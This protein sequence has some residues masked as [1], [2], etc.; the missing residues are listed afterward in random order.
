MIARPTRTIIVSIL[1]V[2]ALIFWC[3]VAFD[4][5]DTVVAGTYRFDGDGVVCS[6]VLKAD[7]TFAQEFKRGGTTSH[8]TGTWRRIGEG[9]IS[10]S[11]GFLPLPGEE[12]EPDGTSFADIH[13]TL[14]FLVT[15]R[16]RRYHVLW[17]GKRTSLTTDTPLGTYDGDEPGTPAVLILH[18]D[19]SFEQ[20]VT[21]R[22]ISSHAEGTWSAGP[23]GEITFSKAFL[24]VSGEPLSKNESAVADDPR[25]SNL[26]I[27]VANTERCT[28]PNLR[29]RYLLWQR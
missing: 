9:G 17:Y 26:Q 21:H 13:K 28:A 11:N 16:I 22:G 18:A 20:A 12:V 5:G 7:H 25:D 2:A 3:L 4:Y 29:K 15:L 8:A 24:K 23:G 1:V 6:L 27:T 19:H 14:G 10:F